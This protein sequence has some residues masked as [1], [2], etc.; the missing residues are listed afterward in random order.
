M[1]NIFLIL[2]IITFLNIGYSQN[3]II[4]DYS[5]INVIGKDLKSIDKNPYIQLTESSISFTNIE[6]FFE[7]EYLESLISSTPYISNHS[8]CSLRKLNLEYLRNQKRI[9]EKWDFSK[10]DNK[11]VK[12][13][14][15]SLKNDQKY[16]ISKPIY[17]ED[18]KF[19]FVYLKSSSKVIFSGE[20]T[21]YFLKIKNGK[22]N[23]SERFLIDFS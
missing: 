10:L 3:I 15:G 14:D 18:N 23:I 20:T 13:F 19:A 6:T 16:E 5:I 8:K 22:W 9:N 1:K 17:S 12:I 4:S 7:F 2:E 11:S 21:I